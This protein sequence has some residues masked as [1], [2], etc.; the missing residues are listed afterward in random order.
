MVLGDVS[1]TVRCVLVLSR[2]LGPVAVAVLTGHPLYASPDFLCLIT[3]D[4]EIALK[5]VSS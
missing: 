3:F 1:L 4:P 2:L 5:A